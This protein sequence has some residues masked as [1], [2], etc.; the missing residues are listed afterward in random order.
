[1][2]INLTING[3]AIQ[4]KE[5]MSVLDAAWAN[6]VSIPTLCHHPDLTPMGAC[7]LCVVEVEKMRGLIASCTLPVSEGM[8]VHTETPKV[9]EERKFVLEMLLTDHPNDCMTCEADG[10]C[11]LQN[12]VYQYQVPWTPHK[13]KT[14][15]YPIGGDPN[16]FVFTDF[17]K[18]ILC[19]RC[20]RA[21]AEIQGRNVW[22]V[23][24][25]GFKDKVVAGA[26]VTMLQA[27]CESC[28]ACA[29]YCPTGAL[30]DKPSRGS[31]RAYQMKKVTTTCVYCGV[32][33]QLDLNVKSGKVV[34][35]TSNAKAPVNGMALCVK[36]RYGH[37]FI[38][39]QDRLTQPLIKKDGAFVESSWDE[40]LT[41]VAQKF[42]E[43]K[44]DSFA[45]LASAKA[46]NEENYLFQKFTRAV[47]GT[48]S[49][50]HCARL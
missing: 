47:M 21:C 35:V 29:A 20:V 2:P 7:R 50:D 45:L 40:A 30:T 14:H 28:G 32:G 25:R 9:V 43:T 10:S 6:G 48:N 23:A 39:H 1:M 33:C 46:T 18:C 37:E 49:V 19:T 31:G 36:G 5:G 8:V 38:H 11:E 42:A 22:G 15:S 41:L 17:N 4:A 3:R 34:K 26:D 44:G 24:N 27:G 13:G 12:A 16:P